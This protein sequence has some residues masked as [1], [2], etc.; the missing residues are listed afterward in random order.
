MV[1]RCEFKEIITYLV[2]ELY[3][4]MPINAD[5]KVKAKINASTFSKNPS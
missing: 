4:T 3:F 2:K 1:M 5:L